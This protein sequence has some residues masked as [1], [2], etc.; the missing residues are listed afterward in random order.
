MC[1]QV[2]AWHF[3][4]HLYE[5]STKWTLFNCLTDL[6]F[7][8]FQILSLLSTRSKYGLHLFSLILFFLSFPFFV[9]MIIIWSMIIVFLFLLH[10][11]LVIWFLYLDMIVFPCLVIEGSSHHIPI[12]TKCTPL[13]CYVKQ[14]VFI[15]FWFDLANVLENKYAKWLFVVV[16]LYWN[17][18]CK[19]YLI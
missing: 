7:F 18:R 10:F 2:L 1:K 14:I 11:I 16:Y 3:D 15:Y 5:V 6:S 8:L 19:L 9:G 4:G 13:K 17:I 12:K